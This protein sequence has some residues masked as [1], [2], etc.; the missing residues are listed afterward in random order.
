M[1]AD[2]L[3]EGPKERKGV[4]DGISKGSQPVFTQIN[5]KFEENRGK[6]RTIRLKAEITLEYRFSALISVGEAY[7]IE[8]CRFI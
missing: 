1:A 6:L 7:L 3:H 4:R 8:I 2:F 5:R